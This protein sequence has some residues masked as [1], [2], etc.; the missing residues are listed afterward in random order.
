MKEPLFGQRKEIFEDHVSK[1]FLLHDEDA[2]VIG[3]KTKH[4]FIVKGQIGMSA[5]SYGSL[6]DHAITAL[7]EGL[8]LAKGTWM[9]TGEGGLSEYHLKGN[10]DIIMQIGPGLFGVRDKEGN[11]NWDAL[12]EK[13]RFHRL[14]HSKLN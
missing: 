3:E 6:G 4:P 10:V 9:N 2:I 14:R 5:M 11:F 12:L 7:S 1:A 8:G 13:V